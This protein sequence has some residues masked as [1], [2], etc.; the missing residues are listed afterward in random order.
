MKKSENAWL[1]AAITFL[2]FFALAALPG[3]RAAQFDLAGPAGSGR[4]GSTV[5]VLPNGNFVVTD[6]F[7]DAPGPITD[8]GAVYLYDGVTLAVISTLT[9]STAGDA[10]G[11]GGVTVLSNGNFVVR[12]PLWANGA[13]INAGAVT[14]GSGTTGVTGVVSV[15]NS[16][17]GSTATDQ[18]G[19]G[20]VTLLS[21]GNFV[22]RSPGWNNGTAAGAGAVTWGSRT[23]GVIGVVSAANSLVGVSVYDQIGSSVTALNNGNYVVSSPSWDNGAVTDAGAVT[24]G[25]GTTGVNGAVSA[26]NSLVG[27]TAEDQVGR[28]VIALKNG[29]YV[30]SS[31]LWDNGAATNV[32]AVTWGSGTTGVT[33]PVSVANS[34]VG[35]TVDDSVGRF[36]YAGGTGVTALNNGN[37]VVISFLWDNGAAWDVG[38]VTW[39]NGT[40]GLTG[41]VSTNNSLIGST[42]GEGIGSFGVTALSNGNYVVS[43]PGWQGGAGAVTWVSGTASVS[44][45]VSAANSLVGTRAGDFVGDHGG[46]T[47]LNNGNYV[48]STP[49]WQNGSAGN[50]G[51]VTWGS[52]TTGVTGPVSTANSLVG[53]KAGDQVGNGGVTNLAN[54]NYVVSSTLWRNGL[55]SLAG[56]VTWASGTAGV[57]GAVSAANSLVGSTANDQIGGSGATALA[58]GNYVVRSAQWDNGVLGN[59]GAVTLGDGTLGITGA[60]TAANSVLGTVGSG[61]GLINFAYELL[62]ARLLVGYPFGNRVSLF[63]YPP[64]LAIALAPEGIRLRF[65]GV[66]GHSYTIERAPAVTG[67]WTTNATPTAPISGQIEHIDTTPPPGQSFYRTVT[68]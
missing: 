56:A 50:A 13:A 53:T 66:P 22:V 58:D 42:A 49:T 9:G 2:S 55:L 32:G 20:G 17:V 8:V 18:I 1:N 59:A 37:Y 3:A 7:Y 57:T 25:N 5:A 28:G 47:A 21:N 48:V 24:W 39:A 36:D 62:N 38:A 19:S 14:W 63:T 34:L 52:G 65:T 10:V 27:S 68:P 12:S 43:S 35:G 54:G 26:I 44:G 30:V 51:A 61:G 46:V 23:T 4:F 60:V 29:N 33:G 6:P 67:P 11:S 15:A 40:T 45:V 31:S 64:T 16:L 41:M